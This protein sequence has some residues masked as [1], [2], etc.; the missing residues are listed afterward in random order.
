MGGRGV[1][2]CDTVILGAPLDMPYPH[3]DSLVLSGLLQVQRV[4]A[5]FKRKVWMV[6]N[7]PL[8]GCQNLQMRMAYPHLITKMESP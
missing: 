6:R 3:N 4:A 2:K 5:R 1:E 8:P 7:V